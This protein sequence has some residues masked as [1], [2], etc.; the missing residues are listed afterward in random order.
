MFFVKDNIVFFQPYQEHDEH[1]IEDINDFY[2]EV[3][4][5]I[6]TVIKANELS[7][8]D[9][10]R[11]FGRRIMKKTWNSLSK[12]K[13]ERLLKYIEITREGLDNIE[14]NIIP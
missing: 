9:V 14:K 5:T 8:V 4:E 10:H 3:L 1:I 7:V 2:E 11:N 13:R 6:C 12:R